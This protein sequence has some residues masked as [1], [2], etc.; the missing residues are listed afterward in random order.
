MM[1]PAITDIAAGAVALIVRFLPMAAEGLAKKSGEEVGKS[2]VSGALSGS[3]K[4]Y[5]ILKSKFLEKNISIEPLESITKT[6]NDHNKKE[7]LQSHLEALMKDDHEF[8]EQIYRIIQNSDQVT[9]KG[10]TNFVNNIQGSQVEKIVQIT[11][12]TGDVNF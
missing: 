7:V 9:F 10:S 6:P 4:I 3:K 5:E 8:C 11:N 2:A 12:V 1:L